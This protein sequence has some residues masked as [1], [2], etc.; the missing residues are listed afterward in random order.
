ML[1]DITA[2]IPSLILCAP[3]FIRFMTATTN[4]ND[5]VKK[6][7][8]IPNLNLIRKVIGDSKTF[9]GDINKLVANVIVVDAS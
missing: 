3:Y 1:T 6:I 5:A 9:R 8:A 4:N 7:H 2:L